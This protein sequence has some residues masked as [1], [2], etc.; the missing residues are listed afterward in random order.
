[1][2]GKYN[3]P[4]S[5]NRLFDN[6]LLPGRNPAFTIIELITVI[7]VIA[8]LVAITIVGYSGVTKSS[9]ET[10]LKSDLKNASAEVESIFLE[11]G[12]PP[13]AVAALSSPS[14]GELTLFSNALL[15][16]WCLSITPNSPNNQ[17]IA[18]FNVSSDSGKIQ[19]GD[20]PTPS[21]QSITKAAC[22][23]EKTVTI[24]ARDKSTYWVK[25]LADGNCWMMTNLAYVGGTSNGGTDI[26]GDVIPRGSGTTGTIDGPGS[27]GTESF[28]IARYYSPS[29]A[30]PTTYP[31]LPSALAD[32]AG[33][34]G[35]LYNWCA[36]M[37]SQNTAACSNT[38][39]P[40]PDVS[41]NICPAG[42]RLP[43]GGDVSEFAT[44]NNV[45]NGGS[46]T[47]PA[48]LLANG[49]FQRGGYWLE[50]DFVGQGV[51]G[52]YWS[53]TQIGGS[54]AYVFFFHNLVTPSNSGNQ[55]NARAV[56][57]IAQ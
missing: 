37:G 43:T 19:E 15:G 46:A 10:A 29:G 36:A 23:V 55:S 13:Q 21:I 17:N 3:K 26:Y 39:T 20:C 5:N 42:W 6:E 11:T 8:I 52:R 54:S 24:D 49:L 57:C 53:S 47:S 45:I 40:A 16:S 14:N 1:M 41:I 22:P 9:R 51:S 25:K 44:L 34:Y 30:N 28:T 12:A 27:P 35:Y 7:T 18:N 48:G 38:T 4:G 33:Q 56:R 32:G 31:T 2:S 50:G